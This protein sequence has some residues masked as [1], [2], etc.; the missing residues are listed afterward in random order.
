MINSRNHVLRQRVRESL[1]E[2]GRSNLRVVLVEKSDL[3]FLILIDHATIFNQSQGVHNHMLNLA[4]LDAIALM[5]NQAI[6][7]ASK[8]HFAT[9]VDDNHIACAVDN[10]WI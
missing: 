5:L 10:L 8:H 2:L 9:L 6:L 4:K 3:L 1:A 7:S